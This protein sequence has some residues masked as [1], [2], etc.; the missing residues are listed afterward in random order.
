MRPSP[1]VLAVAALATVAACG[2]GEPVSSSPANEGAPPGSPN[3][4]ESPA[5]PIVVRAAVDPS[6]VAADGRLRITVTA[7]NTTSAARTLRFS[8]GCT[9][10]Y[11]LLDASGAVVGESGQMCTQALTQETLGAGETLT[12]THVLVRGM[13]GMPPTAPGVYGV[14]GVL[15]TM[16]GAVRSEP[17]AVTFR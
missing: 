7:T 10:D 16:D 12:G 4:S 17:V 2:G 3:V 11:E 13:R 6:V 14:R 5:A 9:T 8:S 1:L 15:L